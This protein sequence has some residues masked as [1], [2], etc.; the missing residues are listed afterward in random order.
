MPKPL[1]REEAKKPKNAPTA[2]TGRGATLFH[3]GVA[4]SLI[5]SLLI[6]AEGI[7]IIIYSPLAYHIPLLADFGGYLNLLFGI[8]ALI[9]FIGVT[10]ASGHKKVKNISAAMIG[11]FSILSLIFFGG[12]FYLGFILGVFGALLTAARE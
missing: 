3:Y 8:I 11:L 4:F 5:A 9:G 2:P 7:K 12:G 1:S 6:I 10:L